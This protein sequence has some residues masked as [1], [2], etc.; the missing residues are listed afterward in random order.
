MSTNCLHTRLARK[1]Y[2]NIYR[3]FLARKLTFHLW[4]QNQKNEKVDLTVNSN[5]RTDF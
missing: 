2:I 1:K 5:L 3:I 4:R